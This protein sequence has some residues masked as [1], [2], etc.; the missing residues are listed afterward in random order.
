MGIAMLNAKY[1]KII[2]LLLISTFSAI[3]SAADLLVPERSLSIIA[4]RE[5]FY[6]EKLAVFVGEK[7]HLFFTTTEVDSSCF[8]LD[9]F[10]IFLGARRGKIAETEL[11]FDRPG[12]FK[13]Y[14]PKNKLQGEFVVLEAPKKSIKKTRMRKIASER[15]RQVKLW[16]PLKE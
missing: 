6:P 16:M 9:Q 11:Y 14:C 15:Q 7:I 5:S 4:S 10:N 3:T 12:R 8:M 13:F 1:W 2:C